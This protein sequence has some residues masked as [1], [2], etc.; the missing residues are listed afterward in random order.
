VDIRLKIL[1]SP[2]FCT[3]IIRCLVSI[4]IDSSAVLQLLGL[5][6]RPARK[7]ATHDAR[8]CYTKRNIPL[9][10][11]SFMKNI[12]VKD[13]RAESEGMD[14]ENRCAYVKEL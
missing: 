3:C 7:T 12:I 11:L 4:D 1:E 13:E 6:L 10:R 8:N 2:L 9:A 5:Y 14:Y